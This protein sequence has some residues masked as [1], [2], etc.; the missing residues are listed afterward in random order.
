M[1]KSAQVALAP[2]KTDD[3]PLM[4][5][6]INDREQVHFN[7]SYKPVSEQQHQEWFEA[8]RLRKDIE[9]F[10]IRLLETGELIGT[11]QLHS[12][13][14]IHRNAELQIRLG[15]VSLRG[16]GYGTEAVRLLLEFA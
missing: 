7:A 15:N 5:D 4:F 12:I 13:N 10:G 8:L 16:Q 11:C 1:L 14:K 9:L 3:L 2:V 6:W